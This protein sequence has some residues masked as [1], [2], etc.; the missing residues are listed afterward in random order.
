M[1]V[2]VTAGR[3]FR[4]PAQLGVWLM[5]AI[6]AATR[7]V[8]AT[9][10]I[11]TS[12]LAAAAL[13]QALLRPMITCLF[14]GEAIKQGTPCDQRA[15]VVK[16]F[17]EAVEA[18]LD[19]VVTIPNPCRSIGVSERTLRAFRQEQLAVSP[20]RFTMLR[21]HLV[22]RTLILSA[23]PPRLSLRSRWNASSGKWGA[24]QGVTNRCPENRHRPRYGGLLS[25]KGGLNKPVLGEVGVATSLTRRPQTRHQR[26]FARIKRFHP[27]RC[28]PVPTPG[29]EDGLWSD[30]P[31]NNHS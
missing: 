10:G 7:S 13:E 6:D 21:R 31:L 8:V 2:T 18:N 23:P 19:G 17:E 28:P 30:C 11:V 29:S 22:R 20:I 5:S 9:P 1:P 3:V 12:P 14:H 27:S 25:F 4:A 16:R 15:A 26:L 24:S